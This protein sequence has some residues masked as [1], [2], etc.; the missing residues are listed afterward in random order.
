MFNE[1]EMEGSDSYIVIVYI[2][3]YI[4]IVRCVGLIMPA[5]VF[6]T[7]IAAHAFSFFLHPI[8]LSTALWRR[9]SC[10]LLSEERPRELRWLVQG[11]VWR[12]PRRQVDLQR[13]GTALLR[14]EQRLGPPCAASSARALWLV[15]ALAEVTDPVAW[16]Q[17][18][19]WQQEPHH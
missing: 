5:T 19:L 11:P 17:R 15:V 2:Q 4:Y 10:V 16:W 18:Q 9:R 1:Q 13:R 8:M 3:I 14:D 7:S 12:L 6:R